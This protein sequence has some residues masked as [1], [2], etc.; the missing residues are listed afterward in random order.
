MRLS[1]VQ[2]QRDARFHSITF[3]ANSRNSW[4][5]ESVWLFSGCS[6]L[7]A[8]H[9]NMQKSVLIKLLNGKNRSKWNTQLFKHI[10]YKQR[11]IIK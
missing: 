10:P 11:A 5:L 6:A 3:M 4:G 2:W 9:A 1:Q 7:D 8:Q